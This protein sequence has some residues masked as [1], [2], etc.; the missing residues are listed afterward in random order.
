MLADGAS[1]IYERSNLTRHQLLIWLGQKLHP[2]IPLYNVAVTFTLAGEV[3]PDRFRAAFQKLVDLSDTLRTVVDEADGAPRQR[4]LESL[5]YELEYLDLSGSAAPERACAERL[6]ARCRE[7]FDFSR[8]LFDSALVKTGAER[9]VWYLNQHHIITDGWSLLLVYRYMA[10]LYGRSVEGRLEEAAA[11]PRFHDHVRYEMEE[12]AAPRHAAAE[13]YWKK[14]LAEKAEPFEPYGARPRRTTRVERHSVDLGAA[15]TQKL[16]ALAARREISASMGHAA[17]FT[18]FA[19]VLFSYLHRAG[20]NARLV[21]GVPFHNRG[22]TPWKDALGLV[23]KV[24]PLEITVERGDTFLS[25]IRKI[26]GEMSEVRPFREI[27][28]AN[29]PGDRVYDV[30]LNYITTVYPDFC[31]MPAHV[32][33]LHTGHER[34]A[35][36]MQV[37]DFDGAGSFTLDL[38]FHCD[39]FDAAERRQATGHFFKMLDAFL[40]NPAAELGAVSLLDEDERR[41][42]LVDFNASDWQARDGLTLPRLFEAR[43]RQHPERTALRVEDGTVGYAALNAHANR[44]ARHLRS[45]GAGPGTIVA[46]CL[47]P[48]PALIAGILAILKAGAAYL[49]LDPQYPRERLAFMLEDAGAAL[50]VTQKRLAEIYPH[51]DGLRPR[52]VVYLDR[53]RDAIGRRRGKNLDDGPAAGDLA[54]VIYTSGSSGAPKGVLV[55]HGAI[56]NRI[57]WGA[58]FYRLGEADRVLQKASFAFDASVWE[59]FEPLSAGAEIVMARPGGR[60]DLDYL[61]DLMAREEVTVAEFPPAL[62]RGLLGEGKLGRCR[63]LKRVFA[64]GEV[65]TAELERRFFAQSGAELYN[66]YGPTEA[67]VDVAH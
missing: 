15:R 10:D 7:P 47:E 3:D 48:S 52:S 53:D 18:L 25:V 59:I 28:L 33:W 16:K 8:R 50:L 60:L 46:L 56:C 37:H 45:L 54:Y 12:Q 40:E 1:G 6:R 4:A 44:L 13:S 36:A 42:V 9:F 5:P 14:K 34:D 41:R 35:M 26:Q 55:E 27:A 2:E 67:S 38:D 43:A 66:T 20:G 11:L 63:A 62:L 49:P 19:A 64:G 30:W 32:E 39:V 51:L 24:I 21:L 57:L 29:P 17:V 58:E 31:G 61:A 65:L 22:A 23:M